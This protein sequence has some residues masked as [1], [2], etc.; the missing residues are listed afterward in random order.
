MK[1]KKANLLSQFYHT[2][3]KD[4]IKKHYIIYLTNK[5]TVI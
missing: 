3:K 2:I 5:L 1:L 4:S